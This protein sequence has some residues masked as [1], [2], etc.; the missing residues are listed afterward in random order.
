MS[1]E[2]PDFTKALWPSTGPSPQPPSENG[3]PFPT[4]K[5]CAGKDRKKNGKKKGNE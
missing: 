1:S 4:L 3:P 2:K 5:K